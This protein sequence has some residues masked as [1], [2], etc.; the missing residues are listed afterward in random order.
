MSCNI[1][2]DTTYDDIYKKCILPN[3]INTFKNLKT[4]IVI[5]SKYSTFLSTLNDNELKEALNAFCNMD[6]INN[7]ISSGNDKP[8]PSIF[9]MNNWIYDNGEIYYGV[10]SKGKVI[11]GQPLYL[12]CKLA[13]GNPHPAEIVAKQF[14]NNFDPDYLEQQIAFGNNNDNLGNSYNCILQIKAN[15]KE[16]NISKNKELATQ[17]IDKYNALLDKYIEDNINTEWEK[18]N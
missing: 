9:N 10:D 3:A 14:L 8:S 12:N 1:K 18:E 7:D 4:P 6:N 15:E 17:K 13:S 2:P 16:L 5:D 11:P